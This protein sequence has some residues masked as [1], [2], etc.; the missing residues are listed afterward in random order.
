[1]LPG[2][3]V[4]G[5]AKRGPSGL[6]GTNRACSAETAAKVL[7]DFRGKA[8]PAAPERTQAAAEAFVRSKKKDVVTFADWK[9]LDAVELE[10]GKAAGKIR[11]K[12]SNVLD[13][14]AALKTV[15]V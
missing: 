3:Y 9:R 5:W 6:I 8:L 4:V 14:L 1:P 15:V 13:A 11:E 12:F 7:E 2:L 10:R